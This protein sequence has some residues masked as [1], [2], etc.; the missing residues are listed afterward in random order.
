MFPM[1]QRYNR[2]PRATLV[3]VTLPTSPAAPFHPVLY[4]VLLPPKEI[5]QT[6]V[7]DSKAS[8]PLSGSCCRM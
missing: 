3:T 6:H 4:P 7:S 8:L 5:S 2:A 1:P